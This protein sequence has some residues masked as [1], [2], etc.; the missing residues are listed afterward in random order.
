MYRRPTV[1][2]FLLP[3]E[4]VLGAF[5]FLAITN[6]PLKIL[7]FRLLCKCQSPSLLGE[8]PGVCVLVCL[9]ELQLTFYKPAKLFSKGLCHFAFLPAM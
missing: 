6:K 5:Q 9:V 3:V 8:Y 1:Y 2:L 7:A 4:G